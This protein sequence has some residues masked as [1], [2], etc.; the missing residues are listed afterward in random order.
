MHPDQPVVGVLTEILLDPNE[1]LTH[2]RAASG[3]IIET[4]EFTSNLKTHPRAGVAGISL[5]KYV[6]LNGL[7]YFSGASKDHGGVRVSKLVAH[8]ET[9]ETL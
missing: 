9:C 8:R 7:L 5:P 2:L 1:V 6:A 4:M 3:D